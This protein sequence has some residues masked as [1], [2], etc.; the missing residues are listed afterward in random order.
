LKFQINYKLRHERH[1]HLHEKLHDIEH[2]IKNRRHPCTRQQYQ[3]NKHQVKA[4]A[5]DLHQIG[6][7]LQEK[8][9]QHATV[10]SPTCITPLSAGSSGYG[11]D[12]N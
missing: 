9:L 5:E 4:I 1:S 12:M 11:S 2:R 3:E 8:F 7:Q 6:M 10:P